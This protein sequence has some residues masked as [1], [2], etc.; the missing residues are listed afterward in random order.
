[1]EIHTGEKT[2]EAYWSGLWKQAATPTHIDINDHRLDNHVNVARHKFLCKA[3][4]GVPSGSALLE[5]GAAHSRWLPYFHQQFGFSVTGLDY[6]EIGCDGAR[7]VLERA[8]IQGDVVCADLFDP[9]A[10]LCGEFDVVASFGVVEHFDNTEQC[11]A[12]CSRYLRR[13]GRIITTIP[14]M[15]GGLGLLQWLVDREIYELHKPLSV[16][17][18]AAAHKNAGLEVVHS[19]FFLSAN[20]R[21]VA[22]RQSATGRSNKFFRHGLSAVTK[23]MWQTERMG[24]GL[25][26]NSFTSPYSYCVAVKPAVGG[27]K[28]S[29]VLPDE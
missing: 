2:S 1:M 18:L 14:N 20:W 5:I 3:L 12:A 15:R 27:P 6:S 8:G 7:A 13:G 17:E 9:P 22:C 29:K 21:A 16:K 4:L 26:P 24:I 11:I 28:R 10:E 25:P 23:L 19:G